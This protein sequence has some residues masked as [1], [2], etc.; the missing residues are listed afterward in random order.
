MAGGE[1]E[2][3]PGCA[4]A[5]GERPGNFD[6]TVNR[7]GNTGITAT[8]DYQ[9][10]SGT[11]ATA[12]EDY[13]MTSVG[14]LVFAPDEITKTIPLTL[15]D[16]TAVEVPETIV[17]LLTATSPGTIRSAP[18]STTVTIRASDQQ[19]DGLISPNVKSGF[20]ANNIYNTTGTDQTMSVVARRTE[21][22]TFYVPIANDGN[23]R[24]TFR[25]TGSA[26]RNGSK[27]RYYSGTTNITTAMRSASGYAIT[28]APAATKKIRLTIT[29]R[30]TAVI[31]STKVASVK[32]AWTGDGT[33]T[34]VVKAVVKVR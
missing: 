25:L 8:V 9:T 29:V 15:I 6:L 2:F 17:V 23:A 32:A 31:R 27:V 4:V 13:T 14:R 7:T 3:C 11:T 12:G 24:N 18:A 5:A 10:W 19:P 22:R 30:P 33:R 21:T 1:G 26:A 16:D 28:L 20:D 34:D